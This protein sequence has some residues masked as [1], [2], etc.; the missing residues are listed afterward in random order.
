MHIRQ[1]AQKRS[2]QIKRPMPCPHFRR[3]KVEIIDMKVTKDLL[4]LRGRL[5]TVFTR[6]GLTFLPLVQRRILVENVIHIA[7]L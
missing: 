4:S 7:S 5:Q 1:F 3:I 6:F 2:N